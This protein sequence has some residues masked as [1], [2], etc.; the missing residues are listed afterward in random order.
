MTG[1]E[2]V[3]AL[4]KIKLHIYSYILKNTKLSGLFRTLVLRAKPSQEKK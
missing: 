1:N 3:S 4:A 2:N